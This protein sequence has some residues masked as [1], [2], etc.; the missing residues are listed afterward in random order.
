MTEL[1]RKE[2]DQLLFLG[3]RALWQDKEVKRYLQ[4]GGVNLTPANFYSSVPLVTDVEGSFEYAEATAGHAPYASSLFDIESVVEFT[5]RIGVH[6]HEF[7]VPVEGDRD[8][9]AGFFWGN[10]AFS[11]SD[12]MAY[13]CV[14]RALKPKRVLEVGSGY[15]TLIADMAIRANGCGEIICVEPYAKPFLHK[16]QS[17]SRIIEKPVQAIPVSELVDLVEASDVWFID[18]THTVKIGSDCLY[19]YLKV[20]PRVD[21]EVVCHSHDIF[22]PYGMPSH[23]ALEKNVFWTEQYL[24]LAYLLDNP[25]AK[26]LF[27]SNYLK[28]AAPVECDAFMQGKRTGGGSSLWYQL[29]GRD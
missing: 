4:A 17:V 16:L 3:K 14:L 20:M 8:D 26:V 27:G 22:L 29:N 9:P 6:A 15:S 5:R 2:L 24:L 12:A 28:R 23:W 21:S 7:D 1:T 25:K 10:P 11:G 19:L 18:S 13:Y